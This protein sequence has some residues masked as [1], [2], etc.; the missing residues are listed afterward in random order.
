MDS[1]S[2]LNKPQL[3]CTL[4]LGTDKCSRHEYIPEEVNRKTYPLA[5]Y[6][7]LLPPSTHDLLQGLHGDLSHMY[8]GILVS[9]FH[10]TE[11]LCKEAGGEDPEGC[12]DV[13]VWGCWQISPSCHNC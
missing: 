8:L 5:S 10:V 7:D 2:V 4:W 9:L 12:G 11:Q 13:E 3:P 1:Q 6:P